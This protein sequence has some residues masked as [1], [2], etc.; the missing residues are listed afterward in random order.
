MI[1]SRASVVGSATSSR[2]GSAIG[3]VCSGT[4]IVTRGSTGTSTCSIILV[5]GN[6]IS[7]YGPSYVGPIA[8]AI[9]TSSVGGEYRIDQVSLRG[10]YRYDQSPYED[11]DFVGDL[12]GFS[13]GIG[14]NFGASRLD[15]A[16]SRTEQDVNSYLF[17]GGVDNAALINRININISL[18]YTLKF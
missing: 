7:T 18:G 2:R 5:S 10:G 9:G 14:Y 16:Y 17:D 11:T 12:N 4:S 8:I 1:A 3:T 6:C 13:A 15:L